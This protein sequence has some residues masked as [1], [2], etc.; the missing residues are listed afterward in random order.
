LYF[1][2]SFLC[3]LQLRRINSG[4][5]FSPAFFYFFPLEQSEKSARQKQR[6]KKPIFERFS[7][8][9]IANTTEPRTSQKRATTRAR[10]PNATQ[11][12]TTQTRTTHTRS[13][14]KATKSHRATYNTTQHQTRRNRESLNASPPSDQE[15][16]NDHQPSQARKSAKIRPVVR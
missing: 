14:K 5:G 13:T 10:E 16:S 1:F 12:A 15:P 4:G 2:L 8:C 7:F 3:F 11:K 6:P 9:P